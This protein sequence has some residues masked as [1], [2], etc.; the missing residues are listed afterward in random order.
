[1]LVGSEF[2]DFSGDAVRGLALAEQA[3]AK[4]DE[5]AE[6]LR[7]ARAEAR[8]G[9]SLQFNGRGADALEHLSEARRLVPK[10]PPSLEYAEVLAAE[11]RALMLN[12][13]SLE[14]RQRLEEA[15]PI[16][17]QFGARKVQASMFNTSRDR[18][19]HVRRVRPRDRDRP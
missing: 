2:A 6:P 9:R 13:R 1:M 12:G 10:E 4:I 15:I 7:A 3:R 16:A 18:V 14:G 11:G 19:R 5:S 17:E 8:I